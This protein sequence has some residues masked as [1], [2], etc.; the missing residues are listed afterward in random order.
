M[1]AKPDEDL[2]VAADLLAESGLAQTAELFRELATDDAKAY[3]VVEYA[4]EYDDC[5]YPMNNHGEQK[6]LFLDQDEAILVAEQ[7]NGRRFREVNPLGIG[8]N[9]SDIS[10]HSYEELTK[11]LS[12]IFGNNFDMPEERSRSPYDVVFPDYATDSQMAEVA[13]LFNM[14]FFQVVEV[15]LKA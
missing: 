10:D 4:F 14:K 12:R 5:F 7:L 3:L 9:W 6:T 1:N 13:K 2:Q 8:E 11:Q 15:D